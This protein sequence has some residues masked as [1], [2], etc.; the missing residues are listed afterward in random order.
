MAAIKHLNKII[1]TAVS[2]LAIGVIVASY[3]TGYIM[4]RNSGNTIPDVSQVQKGFIA[5]SDLEIDVMS[6]D[7]KKPIT[8]MRAY[9]EL[10]GVKFEDGRPVL[11]KIKTT[12]NG[13]EVQE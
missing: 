12:S 11:P 13:Y 8:V 10:Y 7:N 3:T 4:G 5:P 2:T 1:T 6:F 9:G